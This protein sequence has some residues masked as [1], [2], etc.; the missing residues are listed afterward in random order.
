MCDKAYIYKYEFFKLNKPFFS[1]LNIIHAHYMMMLKGMQRILV[2]MP[3]SFQA[4]ILGDYFRRHIGAG[5]NKYFVSKVWRKIT[6]ASF[7]VS[8]ETA[9]F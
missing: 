5:S 8:V 4:A 6:V 2:F 1:S 7:F 3:H 9:L